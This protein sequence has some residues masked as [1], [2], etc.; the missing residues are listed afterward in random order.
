MNG[1]VDREYGRTCLAGQGD[2]SDAES[3]VLLGDAACDR[4][5][6]GRWRGEVLGRGGSVTVSSS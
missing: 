2:A 6:V 3:V 4:G 5:R 1:V